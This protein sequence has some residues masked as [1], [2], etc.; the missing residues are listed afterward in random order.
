MIQFKRGER[1]Y[2]AAEWLATVSAEALYDGFAQGEE[3]K[4]AD[5]LLAF[6]TAFDR[7]LA[8]LPHEYQDNLLAPALTEQISS[9]ATWLSIEIYLSKM[10]DCNIIDL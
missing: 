4:D 5:P 8:P 2:I 3:K 9:V 7:L 6:T 1:L 10:A